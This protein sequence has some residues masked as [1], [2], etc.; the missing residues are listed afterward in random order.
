MMHLVVGL[1]YTLQLYMGGNADPI[2]VDWPPRSRS[3]RGH[4]QRLVLALLAELGV[5]RSAGRFGLDD[6]ILSPELPALELPVFQNL[7]DLG[8][9]LAEDCTDVARL[10]SLHPPLDLL[11][12]PQGVEFS[13]GRVIGQLFRHVLVVHEIQLPLDDTGMC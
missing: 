4:R 3:L 6:L 8:P 10:L 7:R 1:S 12:L 13:S 5:R 2:Q 11:L 9:G